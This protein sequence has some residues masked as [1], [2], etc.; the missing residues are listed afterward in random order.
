MHRG[1]AV[2]IRFQSVS[3]RLSPG[4][5]RLRWFKSIT[6]EV[7][8]PAHGVSFREAT[9]GAANGGLLGPSGEWVGE[10]G[11]AMDRRRFLYMREAV[12]HVS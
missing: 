5:R 6:T 9:L 11:S 12:G 1:S 10:D 4:H 7:L 2:S 3:C 8:T